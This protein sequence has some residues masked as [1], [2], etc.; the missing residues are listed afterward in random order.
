LGNLS[1]VLNITSAPLDF[2]GSKT[3]Y[4]NVLKNTFINWTVKRRYVGNVANWTLNVSFFGN[5]SSEIYGNINI[6]LHNLTS[7][8]KEC[9]GVHSCVR[10]WLS[11]G[12]LSSGG[13]NVTII[14]SN[15]TGYYLDA[16]ENFSDYLESAETSGTI[17]GLNESIDNFTYG[18]EYSFYKNVTL[19][20]NGNSA[21]NSPQIWVAAYDSN[22]IKSVVQNNSCSVVPIGGSCNETF[23]VTMKSTASSGNYNIVWRANWTDNDGSTVG[24]NNYIQFNGMYAIIVGHP[25]LSLSNNSIVQNISDGTSKNI[26]ITINSSGSDS[27]YSVNTMFVEGNLTNQT[28]VL[29][30]LW[31]TLPS[32][33]P[34]IP[35]GISQNENVLITVPNHQAPGIYSGK[36]NLSAGIFVGSNSKFDDCCSVEWFLVSNSIN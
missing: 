33:I 6:S 13:Y 4:M 22:G 28:K 24:G 35:S 15:T 7:S 16:Q 27:L 26:T 23:L 29:P 17:F 32:S 36:L 10:S 30:A 11:P 18:T 14:A 31:V 34:E 20:N 1:L 2:V 5:D 8:K 21:M 12:D 25:I 19:I 9:F 3:S